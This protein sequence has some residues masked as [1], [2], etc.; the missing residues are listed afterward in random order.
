MLD[1]PHKTRTISGS[2]A[3]PLSGLGT[4]C[5]YRSDE[6]PNPAEVSAA[7]AET[8]QQR[9]DDAQAA[10]RAELENERESTQE[11]VGDE[12]AAVFDAHRQFL[13]DPQ[14]TE[15]IE[16]AIADGAAAELAVDNAFDD[17]ITQF[18]GMDGM[19]ADRA[20]DLR[21]VRDRLLRLRSG[22]ERTDLTDLLRGQCCWPSDSHRAIPP[23]LIPTPSLAL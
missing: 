20:D 4:A 21:D 7:A 12:E 6:R 16:A 5:W 10:A 11:R 2:S 19:M 23:S 9:F 14:L 15:Q 22:G 18:A 3:T 13:T 8:E 17:A 1:N